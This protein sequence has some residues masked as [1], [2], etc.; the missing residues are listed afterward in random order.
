MEPR[1]L[2][3]KLFGA[4]LYTDSYDQFK[5][6]YGSDEGITELHATLKAAKYYDGDV[7][8]FRSDYFQE[9]SKKKASGKPSGDSSSIPQSAPVVGKKYAKDGL[10]F[11]WNTGEIKQ[12]G[13][14]PKNYGPETVPKKQEYG[15][16][17]TEGASQTSGAVHSPDEIA[18]NS[19]FAAYQQLQENRG[20]DFTTDAATLASERI[21]NAGKMSASPLESAFGAASDISSG[22]REMAEEVFD[23]TERKP[24]QKPAQKGSKE[25]S[26]FTAAITTDNHLI[27]R[28]IAAIDFEIENGGDIDELMAQ[29]EQLV[30]L[31]S[32]NDEV[33]YRAYASGQFNDAIKY[34]EYLADVQ[35]RQDEEYKN[36]SLFG[37]AA[38]NTGRVVLHSLAKVPQALGSLTDV[39]EKALGLEGDTPGYGDFLQN[40][41]MDLTDDIMQA[42]P[43]PTSL[44]RGGFTNSA[45]WGEFTV[46]FDKDN[47]IS[48]IRDKDGFV[49]NVKVTPQ[50]QKEIMKLKKE[51]M[52]HGGSFSY[53]FA[54]TFGDVGV[55]IL[56]TKG[57]MA[58]KVAPGVAASRMGVGL[59]F[60]SLN[61]EV[62]MTIV[63]AG[64][65]SSGLYKDAIDAGADPDNAARYALGTGL[66]V[67]AVSA[68]LGIGAESRFFNVG[69][70]SKLPKI[71]MGS[72]LLG[73]GAQIA[74][75]FAI[76]GIGEGVEETG[77]ERVVMAAAN[78]MSN[79][80]AGTDLDVNQWTDMNEI[81]TEFGV[82]FATGGLIE[83]LKGGKS[84]PQNDFQRSLLLDAA[85]NP[86][87]ATEA[88]REAAEAI[89][90]ALDDNEE[91]VLA[92]NLEEARQIIE[93]TPTELRGDMEVV[94][95]M[96]EKVRLGHKISA[97]KDE[98]KGLDESF[99][100]DKKKK[101]EELEAK[102]EELSAEIAK[103]SAESKKALKEAQKEPIPETAGGDGGEEVATADMG[104]E[105]IPPAET[106]AEPKP[107]APKDL[108]IEE[109]S[110]LPSSE[111]FD[112]QRKD[113]INRL[114]NIDFNDEASVR[115]G[116]MDIIHGMVKEGIPESKMEQVLKTKEKLIGNSDYLTKEYLEKFIHFTTADFSVLPNEAVQPTQARPEPQATPQPVTPSGL[117]PGEVYTRGDRDYKFIEEKDGVF[118]FEK[119]PKPGE[120]LMNT[121]ADANADSIFMKEL[122]Q[123]SG[124]PAVE[125]VAATEPIEQTP[126]VEQAATPEPVA[127]QAVPP[128]SRPKKE[129]AGTL[130][131]KLRGFY[132]RSLPKAANMT[133]GKALLAKIGDDNPQTYQ[134]ISIKGEAD[135]IGAEIDAD[136][137][138]VVIDR[139]LNPKRDEDKRVTMARRLVALEVVGDSMVAAN[140][141]NDTAS[142]DELV[143]IADT[144][145]QLIG[146]EGTLAGQTAALIGYHSMSPKGQV[147]KAVRKI[148]LKRD[149]L[150]QTANEQGK[151]IGEVVDN[152]VEE[153][154]K[155][156]G[157][158]KEEVEE[159]IKNIYAKTKA[160]APGKKTVEQGKKDLEAARKKLRR[161]L[162]GSLSAGY[163]PQVVAALIDIFKAHAK[164]FKGN[165]QKIKAAFNKDAT[166]S[167]LDAKEAWA[168]IAN[169]VKP[170]EDFAKKLED[171]ISGFYQGDL[172]ND[173][174]TA[175]TESGL[176]PA[177]AKTLADELRAN[178]ADVISTKKAKRL[179][180]IIKVHEKS[181]KKARAIENAVLEAIV[182]GGLD[183]NSIRQAVESKYGIKSF[184]SEQI[185]ELNKMVMDMKDLPGEGLKRR[186]LSDMQD[187]IRT[188]QGRDPLD[189]VG[190][191]WFA[192]VLSDV[193]TYGSILVGNYMNFLNNWVH[194]GLYTE[195]GRFAMKESMARLGKV[196][197]LSGGVKQGV[198]F[199]LTEMGNFA[200]HGTGMRD[201]KKISTSGMMEV[202][203]KKKYANPLKDAINKLVTTPLKMPLRLIN[204]S[205]A[206][207]FYTMMD[208]TLDRLAYNSAKAE[209]LT[210]EAARE[211]A[212]EIIGTTKQGRQDLIEQARKE[213][214]DY[215]AAKGRAPF[216]RQEV[217]Y[218]AR[219]IAEERL[220]AIMQGAS[221]KALTMA[222]EVSLQGSP[223]GI[224]GVVARALGGHFPALLKKADDL[225]LMEVNPDH[226]HFQQTM[227]KGWNNLVKYSAAGT[228]V[229]AQ[230]F[231]AFMKTAA[232]MANMTSDFMPVLG[233]VHKYILDR[234]ITLPNGMEPSLD[235]E[236]AEQVRVFWA[237]QMEGSAIFAGILL[238]AMGKEE[239]DDPKNWF[240]TGSGNP[241]F[242]KKSEDYSKG[243]R[244]YTMHFGGKTFYYRD[245]P[246]G[247]V[248]AWAGALAD[249]KRF[250]GEEDTNVS[251]V[252]MNGL[253]AYFTNASYLQSISGLND[254][255]SSGDASKVGLALINPVTGFVNPGYA[256]M[257]DRVFSPE[258]RDS[259]TYENRFIG[260]LQAKTMIASNF[261]D[262]KYN[263]MGEPVDPYK[264]KSGFA[265]VTGMDKYI[266]TDE[267]Y[268]PV[269][270][271]LASK[272]VYFPKVGTESKA[273][274]TNMDY[275][276][277]RDFTLMVGRYRRLRHT[278]NVEAMKKMDALQLAKKL[279]AV[280]AEAKLVAGL[281]VVDARKK[282][283]KWTIEEIDK[284]FVRYE[285]LIDRAKDEKKDIKEAGGDVEDV[286]IPEELDY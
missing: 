88:I 257:A 129:K 146:E 109:L 93:T 157:L 5:K 122:T 195:G 260:G 96:E 50:Q 181:E 60:T 173:L 196:G 203:A 2:Y 142:L 243:W 65:M 68:L 113:A 268:N 66:G 4:K 52:F 277:L 159:A 232:N 81:L 17:V 92:T 231:F 141:A 89:G 284:L 282:G 266:T 133:A 108:T 247:A 189:F 80:L 46:D 34:Q 220:D 67:G 45:K 201:M 202:Q 107:K 14:L 281:L 223:K 53:Q 91:E 33:F 119:L 94:A 95:L 170:L 286:E 245:S 137:I 215:A 244:P 253:S 7:N 51:R 71:N 276:E 58:M 198:W 43:A 242:Y 226:S 165:I 182:L 103:K 48:A 188:I 209:G 252:A 261:L 155:E 221:K 161:A 187:Y 152:I 28:S 140:D 274:G 265:Q 8:S 49:A 36:K 145:E 175:L 16:V 110:A 271:V 246:I 26:A 70:M 153:V 21:A 83:F 250:E 118:H 98:I 233:V 128:P 126:A 73:R 77:T 158:T 39:T 273:L 185:A 75:G 62:A 90:Q 6:D 207:A 217:L 191:V 111:N 11:N 278:P 239:D 205:D 193:K 285:E 86:E 99:T 283:D 272:G 176:D 255:L 183:D 254:G 123:K 87:R 225:A 9:P 147:T 267:P 280:D 262:L 37:K 116:V 230:L 84:R 174:E 76:A 180:E 167:G 27:D 235:I 57:L 55:Q 241:D 18:E 171:T 210:G 61:P 106:V 19:D 163:N 13:P 227:T 29:K 216:S 40:T 31:K 190:E 85:R 35:K 23:G 218:R 240:I 148:K 138:D 206:L 117:K 168:A 22:A 172:G 131:G 134:Q 179:K 12:V 263:S 258:L 219:E 24:S 41:A 3:E 143:R 279:K 248:L 100:V 184:T 156:M 213:L 154:S 15:L 151:P 214:D 130:G 59:K 259:K 79:N 249:A 10:E 30:S 32:K 178:L 136:G 101:L 69:I 139:A 222:E 104:V 47:N 275:D 211:R 199:G 121:K 20:T 270:D 132:E 82:S 238:Y 38:S 162:G 194:Y 224:M 63:N 72:S 44:Q 78:A 127:E 169:E 212:R 264:K 1:E 164:I 115:A 197:Q 160:M 200:R 204:A 251:D 114:N 120:T 97:L 64:M 105:I 236:D 102:R 125:P 186:A 237:R 25:F 144:L 192:S 234:I 54:Q 149:K 166:A 228:K 269:Y 150:R 42:V 56:G 135:K 256:R 229:W 124:G 208:F 112:Q 177:D 74:G